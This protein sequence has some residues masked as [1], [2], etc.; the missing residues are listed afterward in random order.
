MDQLETRTM[1]SGATIVGPLPS[2][3]ET[4]SVQLQPGDVGA[5]SQLTPLISAADATVQATTISG[6]YELE[7][8]APIMAQLAEQLSASPAVA[9]AAA[10]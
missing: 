5:L 4:L 10:V 7:G 3:Q 6:L 8:P 9:Y 2:P 1:L